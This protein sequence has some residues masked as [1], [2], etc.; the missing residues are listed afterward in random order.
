MSRVF[1]YGTLMPGERRWPA[2]EPL[3][4]GWEPATARGYLWDTGLGY[5]A[6]RFDDEGGVVP[7]FLVTLDATR[8]SDAVALLDGIERQGMLFRRVEVTTSGG[9]A[10]SYEWLGSTDGLAPL[11][12]GWPGP[13]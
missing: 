4:T 6:V 2:L 1:V 10:I 13:A 12:G 9:P 3:A 8:L 11:P 5:P 7:G